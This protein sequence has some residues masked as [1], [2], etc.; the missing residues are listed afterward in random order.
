MKK[1]SPGYQSKELCTLFS[2]PLSTHYYQTNRQVSDEDQKT[3]ERIKS[4]AIET[5]HTY[6]KRRTQVELA[7]QGIEIGIYK[8]ASLMKKANVIAIKPK[9]RHSYPSGEVHKKAAHLLKRQFNPETIHTHWVGDI[10]YIKTYTGWSYLACILDLGSREIMGWALSEEPNAELAK[11]ALQH[12]IKKHQPNTRQLMFH[13]DQGVQYSANLFVD[14]LNELQLTQS[15]SRRG[16]CWDNAVMER[17]FR[18]LKTEQLNYLS[19]INH[20]SVIDAVTR[21]I[22]FYN[23]KRLHSAIDYM[24]PHQKT[25][26]MKKAA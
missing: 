14:Y 8:I 6:G 15:M 2:I 1:A 19:F 5:Q 9:K 12:A 10:T 17:F 25:N 7:N 22:G 3:I 24:T 16:N 18:N 20:R 11:T 4:I 21:Y 26:E 23:Y 13:S